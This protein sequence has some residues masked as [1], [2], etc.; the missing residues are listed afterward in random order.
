MWIAAFGDENAAAIANGGND[1]LMVL[2]HFAALTKCE[3]KG[4]EMRYRHFDDIS[5][6]PRCNED[7]SFVEIQC[8]HDMNICW[9]VDEHGS[10]TN[11]TRQIGKPT[12]CKTSGPGRKSLLNLCLQ[13]L[14]TE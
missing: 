6:V 2:F 13:T 3:Y 12:N 8:L 10:E 9:C 11:G 4:L 14:D 1:W 5:T 7:G